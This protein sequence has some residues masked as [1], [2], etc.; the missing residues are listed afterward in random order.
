MRITRETLLKLAKE[1]TV[2]RTR[3][4][5]GVIAV[6]LVGS[7]LEHEPLLG[8]TGD[9]DLVFIH[10]SQPP[11]EREIVPMSD[12]VHIDIAHYS[13]ALFRQPRQLRLDPWT[14]PSIYANPLLLHD[15]QHW[16]EF[17]QAS[18]RSQFWRPENTLER[19]RKFA[20]SARR[21][22]VDM[23][24][25][26]S[27][28]TNSAQ[29]IPA[30]LK[31][32]GEAANAIASL[33]APPLTERRFLQEFPQRAALAGQS[34]L[35]EDLSAL[36]G[37]GSADT[38]MLQGWL[39]AWASAFDACSAASNLPSRLHP[40]R[41]NYYLQAMEAGLS[42]D[43]PESILWPLLNT[44]STVLNTLPEPGSHLEHWSEALKTLNLSASDYA[45]RS[46]YLDKFLDRI[47]EL[48]DRWAVEN[49]AV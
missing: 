16:F 32:V 35:S 44:W 26:L 1:T 38:A 27:H 20:D 30:Y 43:H 10:D 2:E 42:S 39:P 7:L 29:F 48:L 11:E 45:A 22:W 47:E 12:E 3:L 18:V 5:R 36:V 25:S 37:A 4:D 9:I 41:K 34:D 46:G 8:G 24:N 15:T 14:G 19:A 40:C 49:G 28:A 21:R 31:S 23:H 6:Y 13:Q 17:A 33:S